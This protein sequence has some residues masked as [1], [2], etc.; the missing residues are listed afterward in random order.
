MGIF[1]K[2]SSAGIGSGLGAG[3]LSFFGGERRNLSQI[4]SAREMMRFQERMSNTAYQRQMADL[5][6]AGLNPML[7]AKLGGASS[8]GGAM[9]QIQDT[10]TPAVTSAK[11]V[12]TA[13]AT[14]HQTAANTVSTLADT[15][16]GY[17]I[18]AEAGG[19]GAV[20]DALKQDPELLNRVADVMEKQVEGWQDEV[21]K[22]LEPLMPR[23]PGH[24][25][26]EDIKSGNYKRLN[27]SKKNAKKPKSG[28][29]RGSQ[30]HFNHPDAY[31]S[32]LRKRKLK[33]G[34]YENWQK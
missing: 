11:D 24:L 5:R 16:V 28:D 23:A 4:S 12:A 26:E 6:A 27:S 9:P 10:I 14:V 22:L 3:L 8:P 2:L 19:A 25:S 33:R 32:I 18:L 13:H 20:L 29:A 7:A 21:R 15:A 1:E 31:K 34:N 17:K 30:K